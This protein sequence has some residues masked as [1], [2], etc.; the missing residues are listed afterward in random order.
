ME[1]IKNFLNNSDLIR[2]QILNDPDNKGILNYVYIKKWSSY[3]NIK[4]YSRKRSKEL[5]EDY[6]IDDKTEKQLRR[7]KVLPTYED[8]IYSSKNKEWYY[9]LLKKDE[10][11]KPSW[12]VWIKPDKYIEQLIHNVCWWDKKNIE[13]LEKAILYKY[14]NIDSSQVPAI[15]LYGKWWSGKW[16]F[17][18]LLSSIFWKSNTQANLSQSDLEN[19]YSTY[20][21]WKLIVEFAEVKWNNQNIFTN[22]IINK[23]KNLILAE[24]ITVNRKYI[25]QYEVDNKAWFFI[26]SNED[27]PIKLDTKESW[28][29]RFSVIRSNNKLTNKEGKSI[30]NSIN[31]KE[32]VSNFLQ[33]LIEKYP[34]VKEYSYFD[35]L[36]NKDKKDL[37]NLSNSD[38]EDEILEI[39]ETIFEMKKQNILDPLIYYTW[40]ELHESFFNLKNNHKRHL[41]YNIKNANSLWIRLTQKIYDYTSRWIEVKV[42]STKSGNRKSYSIRKIDLIDNNEKDD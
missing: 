12:K 27:I 36:D 3:L 39:I 26:T 40:R 6:I 19:P 31:N 4:D 29:R 25:E 30:N 5:R 33:Y 18:T 41:N 17:I 22:K 28:N 34:E 23:L 16:T 14:Y 24:K 2:N 10:I 35:A 42:N 21:W 7:N 32:K 37:E 8:I 11:I 1:I 38:D 15:I 13:Y 20:K 9:N